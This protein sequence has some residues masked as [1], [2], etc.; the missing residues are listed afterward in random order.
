MNRSAIVTAASLI[1]LGAAFAA[2]ET[3][4]ASASLPAFAPAE[5]QQAVIG[6][7][8]RVVPQAILAEEDEEMTV[9]WVIDCYDQFGP[10][11]VSPDVAQ[12]NSCMPS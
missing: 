3:G 7:S 1:F 2:H 8:S 6:K 5:F 11:G 12:L 9:E 4:V 10:D